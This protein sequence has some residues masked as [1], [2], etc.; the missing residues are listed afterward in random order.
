MSGRSTRWTGLAAGVL[1]VVAIALGGG[2]LGLGSG[3]RTNST[4]VARKAAMDTAT[5]TALRL[6]AYDY[7]KINV[8]FAGVEPQ[9][10]GAALAEFT[11]NT[12]AVRTE[13][14][15][16]KLVATS[17]LLDAATVSSTR[18]EA[19]VLVSVRVSVTGAAPSNPHD[20]LF[21]MHLIDTGGRW[22]VDDLP[23][24]T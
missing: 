1:L 8:Q 17:Q 5:Q 12:A 4:L 9:L 23:P 13:Y 2:W 6:T 7:R 18:R 15:A 24:V 20:S 11:Q 3:R 14:L 16:G 10:T 22:V 21:R 19:T